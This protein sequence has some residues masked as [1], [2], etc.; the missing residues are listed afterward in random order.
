[1]EESDSGNEQD[2]AGS[3]RAAGSGS[4]AGPDCGIWGTVSCSDACA[5]SPFAFGFLDEQSS[6]CLL[7]LIC[8][9]EYCLQL[10]CAHLHGPCEAEFHS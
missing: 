4:S 2:A 9:G 8:S 5:S 6:D 7:Q 1:M 3:G 10:H